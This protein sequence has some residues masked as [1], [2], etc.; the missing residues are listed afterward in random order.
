VTKQETF[1][2]N[3]ERMVTT[4][5]KTAGSFFSISLMTIRKWHWMSAALC[6]IC[7]L[8][9]SV[10]GITLHH[11]RIFLPKPTVTLTEGQ[12]PGE[13]L[14]DLALHIEQKKMGLPVPMVEWFDENQ[15]I[16]VITPAPR[17]IEAK[18]M[19]GKASGENNGEV[20][21]AE[22]KD[23]AEKG[24]VRGGEIKSAER[25]NRESGKGPDVKDGKLRIPQNRP[26]EATALTINLASGA[27]TY[28]VTDKGW[29]AY[30]NDL[31]KGKNTGDA[32]VYFIDI[33]AIACIIFSITGFLLL[34]RYA[35][36]RAKTWP[37]LIAGLVL[38]IFF[39]MFLIH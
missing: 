33:F 22:S 29:L 18:A 11:S 2:A 27:F 17:N 1:V 34:Q 20:K 25:N 26:G 10:T 14:P 36:T 6:F 24:E 19:E 3:Q 7:M 16:N 12:L 5:K 4:N 30:L 15:N 21:N 13:L 35:N 32:W 38:P 31:H 37:L 8:L 39:M 28:E 9:F 23:L